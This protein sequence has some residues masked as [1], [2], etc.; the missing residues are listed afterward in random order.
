MD[1]AVEENCFLGN[2]G[3]GLAELVARDGGN[4]DA[5]VKDLTGDNF[6]EAQ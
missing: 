4:V 3:E 2:D 1:G 6:G 5:V